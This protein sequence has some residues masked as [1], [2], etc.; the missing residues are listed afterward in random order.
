MGQ[1]RKRG[2]VW[3]IRYYRNGR[4]Y[5]ESAE[6]HVWETAR[7]LL[8]E[9][10]GAIAKG[11]PVSPALTKLTFDEAVQDVL[12]D[13]TVNGKKTKDDV[14]RRINKHLTP[15]FGGKRLSAITAADVR[16]FTARRLD[17]GATHGEIN[18]ELA[19][20]RRAFRLAVGDERY[21]GHVP[22]IRMLQERNV[23]TGFFDDAMLEA[24]RAHLPAALQPV[25]TFGYVTGWRIQSEVLPLEWRHIDRKA[26]EARLEPGSTK[27]Q[28]G[29]TFPFTDAL[30]ALLDEQWRQHQALAQAGTICRYVFHRHGKPH[31]RLSA[32]RGGAPARPR[33]CRDA[34]RMTCDAQRSATWNARACRAAWPCS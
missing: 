22:K 18:R 26:G 5:E 6:T 33:A 16:A 19:I 13:Y 7:D 20:V 27:N 4:R 24:V 14:E 1:L 30:R 15:F 34:F 28:D 32:R 21:H 3:W 23:R 2:N 29:R 25:V 9:K 8:R 10:E 11:I 31:Q 17:A 12:S